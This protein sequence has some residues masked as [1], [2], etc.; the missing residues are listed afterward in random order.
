[1]ITKSFEGISEA[2]TFLEDCAYG[3]A[4]FDDKVVNLCDCCKTAYTKLK[5]DLK[6]HRYKANED[7]FRNADTK[8]E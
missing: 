8:T 2:I 5:E 6:N 1:M 3:Y 7:F 4:S